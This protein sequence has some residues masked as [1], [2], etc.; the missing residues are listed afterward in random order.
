MLVQSVAQLTLAG[1]VALMLALVTA[2]AAKGLIGVGMPI[3]AMPLVSHIMDLPAAVALLSIPLVLS[4]LRQAIEGGG[5]AAALRQLAPLLVGFCVGIV[6][7]VKVLMSLD[8]ALLKPLVGCALLLAGLSVVAKPDLKL[9]PAGERVAGPIAGALGG[10]F[11]GLAALSGPIVFV[12]LLATS[13]DKNLF[14]KHASLYLVFASAVLLLLVMGSYAHITLADA[15]VSLVSVLPVMLGMALGARIRPRV[16]IR[17]FRLLIC[18]WCSPA[19]SISSWRL[20]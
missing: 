7:G 2:G 9:S 19:R 10:V 11:G 8:D 16:P 1:G 20:S 4:N 13:R 17:L 12:Y 15:G 3:V 5:T 6:V 14:V 18:W